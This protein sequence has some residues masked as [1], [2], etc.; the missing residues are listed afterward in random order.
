MTCKI[1]ATGSKGN[2][3][4]LNGKY[5]FDCGVPISRLDKVLP[6]LRIVFLTHIHGD[7][8]NRRAIRNIHYHRPGVRFACGRNLLVP[9]CGQCGVSPA[10]VIVCEPGK[11][12]KM[13]WGDDSITFQCIDLIH[14]VENVGWIVETEGQQPGTAMYA[15]DTKYIPVNVPGLD[16][17]MVERNYRAEELAERRAQKIAA[18]EYVYEHK[19]VQNHM[20]SQTI[21]NWLAENARSYSE[22]VFLHQHVHM[23]QEGVK[24]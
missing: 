18:G 8:F 20:S 16:L 17:Y 11:P 10:N 13:C 14:D 24:P 7:H 6:H 21:D 22:V 4:V 2:A 15:T 5:L 12:V 19:V 3:V 1:I 9:L 23:E